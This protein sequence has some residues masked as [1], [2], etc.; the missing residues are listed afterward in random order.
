MGFRV[1]SHEPSPMAVSEDSPKPEEPAANPE[2]TSWTEVRA[3]KPK[4]TRKRRAGRA[5]N[6]PPA[7]DSLAMERFGRSDD[8]VPAKY[9]RKVKQ[10][11][12]EA[13]VVIGKSPY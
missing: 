12:E 6:S 3:T 11:A 5:K 8:Y 1:I 2:D 10:P 7:R 9:R 4:R 13:K